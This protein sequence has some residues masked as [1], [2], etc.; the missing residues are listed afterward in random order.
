MVLNV[1]SLD[2]QHPLHMRTDLLEMKILRPY[3]DLLTQKL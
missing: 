1:W 2:Q 3:P